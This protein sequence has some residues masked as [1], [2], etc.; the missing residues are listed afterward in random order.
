MA[1]CACEPARA[2]PPMSVPLK[3]PVLCESGIRARR[4]TGTLSCWPSEA[5]T[6]TDSELSPLL[7]GVVSRTWNTPVRPGARV[8]DEGLTAPSVTAFW[9]A[10]SSSTGPVKPSVP[11]LV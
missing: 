10:V 5:E 3:V 2:L 8:C 4:V 1:V 7:A 9:V 11:A 6:S